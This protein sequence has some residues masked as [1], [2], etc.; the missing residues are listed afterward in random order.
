[1]LFLANIQPDLQRQ[2][3]AQCARRPLLRRSTR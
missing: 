3:R 2:V 1:M